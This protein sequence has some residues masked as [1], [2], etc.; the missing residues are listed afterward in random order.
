VLAAI[1][2]EGAAIFS[3]AHDLDQVLI[4]VQGGD[5]VPPTRSRA[6]AIRD[7]GQLGCIFREPET[8]SPGVLPLV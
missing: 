1:D 5:V 3:S 6:G 2:A 8:T 7:L 4:F